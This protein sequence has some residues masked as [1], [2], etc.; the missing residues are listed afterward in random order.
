METFEWIIILLLGAAL[1]TM[2]ARRLGAPYPTFLAIGGVLIALVPDSPQ[3]TLDP[4][5]A[6]ALFVAPVLLDAAYDTSVRD[7]RDNWLP[8]AGLVVMAVVLTTICVA[9]TV[10]WLV[11]GVS[12]PVAIALGAI[13]A[14]PDAAAAAAIMRQVGLPHRLLKI[15]EGES[16]LND[17]SALLIYKLALMAVVAGGL[18]PNSFTPVLLLTLLGSVAAGFLCTLV[19]RPLMGR[20]VDVPTALIVQFVTTFGIWIFAE[21]IG[22]SGILTIVVYAMTIART[23]GVRMPAR[24][25]VPVYAV[26][27]TVVFILNAFAFVL[28]GM[29]LR[30]IW[31]RLSADLRFEY[32]VTAATVLLVTILI[33]FAWVMSYNKL[34]RMRIARHG[35][36]PRR[37]MAQPTVG[38]AVA[39]S[40][41]GMRGIVTLA[42][43]F[44]IPETLPNGAPFPYRDLILLTAFAVVLGTLVIQGLTLKP[45]IRWLGLTD[46]DPV[47]HEVKLART[48]AYRAALATIEKDTTLHGI[49]LRKEYNAA[50]ELNESD[51]ALTGDTPGGPLRREAI[52]AARGRAIELRRQGVIGDDAYH[53]LEEELDWAE[54]SA[55]GAR[56]S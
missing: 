51:G 47:G 40:W 18:S 35:F 29:Q 10:R 50:V 26:W 30:P 6:L 54:M 46:D 32:L 21:R 7:L 37:P 34:I 38:G 15:L 55:G 3:W 52:A 24:Q 17:A 39:I 25:R 27:E 5:L 16:L 44:A 23:G 14:P 11:P 49:I 53:I 41:A 36:H 33:R 56:R 31:E 4:H 22:L 20:L 8:V 45:L 12:W 48:Q 13:V 42:A 43:A 9:L 28:I 2:L 1:L 19:L